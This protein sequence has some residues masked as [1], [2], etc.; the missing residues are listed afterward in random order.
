MKSDKNK[1]I[2]A[3]C[4]HLKKGYSEMSFLEA[5][6]EDVENIAKQLDEKSGGTDYMKMINHSRREGRL[7]C[8]KLGLE[9]ISGEIPKF[10][11]SAWMFL[12]KNR[13]GWKDKCDNLSSQ[14]E[15][16]INVRLGFGDEESK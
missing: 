3:Y 5:D 16:I 8:E 11:G 7:L 6:W 9:G 10:N 1:I 12:M 14:E 2:T 4:N 15:K 13:F